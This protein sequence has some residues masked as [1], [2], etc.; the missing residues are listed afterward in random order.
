MV[1]KIRVVWHTILA[2]QIGIICRA[3]F[4][5]VFE[6]MP[7]LAPGAPEVTEFLTSLSSE[8]VVVHKFISLMVYLNRIQY[9][10]IEYNN[11]EYIMP[12]I[13]RFVKRFLI[14]FHSLFL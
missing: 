3:M 14:E 9:N 10:I 4:K 2:F 7:L 5:S 12:L 13:I 11:I 1:L 6:G 8:F